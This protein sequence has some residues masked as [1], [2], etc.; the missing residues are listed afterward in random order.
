MALTASGADGARVPE[1]VAPP[2]RHPRF[3]LTVGARGIAAVSILIGHAWW[4]SGGFG[5][6]G[7]T[8]PNRFVVRMDGMVAVFFMLSGFLL[9]RPMI[10]HRTGGPPAPRV[11]SYAWR[12]FLRL[13][14]V[15]WV[16]LTVLAVVVG[17]YGVFGEDWWRFYTL[18]SFLDPASADA[19]CSVEQGPF[20]GLPQS[21]TL[22]VEMTFYASLPLIAAL[23]GL[24]ARG[25]GPR[26]WIRFELGLLAGLA[27]LALFLGGPPLWLRDQPWFKF[28]LLGHFYWFALGLGIAVLSVAYSDRALPRGLRLAATRPGACWAAAFVLYLVTVFAFY[29]VPFPVAPFSGL[30]YL[31]LNL[32]QGVA[33]TLLFLPA[34]FAN[35]NHGLPARVLGHPA[36]MWAGLI[37]YGILLWHFTID[38]QLG[39]PGADAG[40]WGVLLIGAL[41]TIPLAA[42]SYYVV[43]RPLMKL[44]Y[45]PLREVLR[46]GRRAESL[47]LPEVG[48]PG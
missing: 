5:G 10:A 25:R 45:R 48:R 34:V 14:P 44:K 21:W 13:F 22:G 32:T 8:L 39:V 7:D 17:L 42:V 16:V 19:G 35:P 41:L 28:S 23:T 9:Y 31:S 36:V 47:P 29:A 43:E 3:P 33:A 20:C 38:A 2:P 18:T 4:F 6:L 24:L 46:P 37:S 26:N 30:E 11:S 15:Y 27:M 1:A 40:F 12:R